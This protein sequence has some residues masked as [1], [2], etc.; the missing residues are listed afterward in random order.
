MSKCE[1]RTL[2]LVLGLV[3]A[4][5]VG[6]GSEAT[7]D[8]GDSTTGPAADPGMTAGMGAASGTAGAGMSTG[9]SG[10]PTTGNTAS[11]GS[12]ATGTGGMAAATG[13]MTA[14]DAGMPDDTDAMR[15]D[16][17]M[18]DGK[19]VI[20]I[21]D[22]FMNLS[23]GS[24]IEFSLDKISPTKY[25]HYGVPGTQ[26]LNGQIPSQ[27]TAAKAANPDIKT[28]LMTGGGNDI[29]LDFFGNLVACSGAKTEADLKPACTAALDK[30]SAGADKMFAEMAA[31]G[32]KDIVYIG[33]GYPTLNELGGTIE[34]TKRIQAEKCVD[35]SPTLGVRCHFIDPS[36]ELIGLISAD[37]IHPTVA[38]YDVI[39]KM[40]W[41]RMMDE[42]VRR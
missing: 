21:G 18:G 14:T 24:G 12:T 32:V 15:M 35:N 4:A 27:Y 8:S 19:D 30:I 26:L 5:L 6:C 9:S 28:V 36:K 11:G 31:D 13:G 29:I 41:K 3:G 10:K 25:R 34:R 40:V 17:G 7:D 38:G 23:V 33:Y 1:R 39:A 20:T 37:G 16:E 22:S 42:G 2:W